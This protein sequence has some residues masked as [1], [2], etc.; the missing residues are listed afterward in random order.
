MIKRM[1]NITNDI[2]I[3]KKGVIWQI[4]VT[5]L[6]LYFE[7][8]SITLNSFKVSLIEV[9]HVTF[10]HLKNSLNMNFHTCKWNQMLSITLCWSLTCKNTDV[11]FEIFTGSLNWS[12]NQ[13]TKSCWLYWN[14]FSS[15]DPPVLGGHPGTA[16]NSWWRP[17]AV[18]VSLCV[19]LREF[20]AFAPVRAVQLTVWTLSGPR[21]A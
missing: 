17:S 11:L 21:T 19:D 18:V 5:S 13:T 12:S 9:K 16:G 1:S 10:K 3:N 2:Y 4:L 14:T 6:W 8:Y 15:E 7:T 20:G